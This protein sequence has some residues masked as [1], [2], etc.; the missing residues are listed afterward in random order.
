VLTVVC[1]VLALGRHLLVSEALLSVPPFALFRYPA[2]YAVGALFGISVLAGFGARRLVAS[3]RRG[4]WLAPAAI[5]GVAIGLAAS[6]WW[7]W[8]REGFREHA[9]WLVLVAGALALVRR[10]PALVAGVIALELIAAPV[11]RWARLPAPGLTQPSQLAPLLRDAGR[12]SIRVDLDDVDHEACGPWD[13]EGDPLLEGRNRLAALRFVEEGLSATGGY[14]FRDPWR[15]KE[16]FS[17]GEGAFVA[18]GVNTFVRETWAPAPPGATSVSTTPLEDVWLWRADHPARRGAFFTRVAVTDEA[19]ALEALGQL[20]PHQ[21]VVEQGEPLE[22]PPCATSVTTTELDPRTV[23]QRLVAC[24]PGVVLLA[25]AWFP[26]WRVEVDGAEAEPLRAWGFLR[27]VRVPAGEHLVRWRYE[28]RSFV[29][30]AAI[31]LFALFVLL[32]TLAT[33]RARFD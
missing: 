12:V 25:D 19:R 33:S 1:L 4:R 26:G 17:H 22:G 32:I 20:D 18:A 28:P 11:E 29:L 10:R 21:I 3:A 13:R 30:G 24:A 9:W 8:A 23:E 14:G 31:S 7:P 2:K 5:G 27:A 15:L 6:A 16:A